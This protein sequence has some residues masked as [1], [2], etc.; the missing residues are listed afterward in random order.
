[1]AT[2]LTL[3]KV[4]DSISG[5]AGSWR[6]YRAPR[7]RRMVQTDAHAQQDDEFQH[8]AAR[9]LSSYYSVFVARLAIMVS[10]I[11]LCF[12]RLLYMYVFISLNMQS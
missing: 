8:A 3:K 7:G 11:I 9:C 6:R 4:F 5:M 1:M 10:Q 12:A 2:P